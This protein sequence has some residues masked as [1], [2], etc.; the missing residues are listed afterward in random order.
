[1]TFFTVCVK[2]VKSVVLAWLFWREN[3]TAW[4]RI[5]SSYGSGSIADRS[6]GW[7]SVAS[8]IAS[9]VACTRWGIQK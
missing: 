1:L 4:S 5:G 3:S 7:C 6:T 2:K 9:I 8:F